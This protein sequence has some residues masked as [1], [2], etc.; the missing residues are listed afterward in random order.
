MVCKKQRFLLPDPGYAKDIRL[1]LVYLGEALDPLRCL[2]P[3]YL[4]YFLPDIICFLSFLNQ[5]LFSFIRFIRCI[6]FY[7]A[8][9]FIFRRFFNTFHIDQFIISLLLVFINDFLLQLKQ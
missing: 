3:L 8:F 9:L 6:Q 5:R 7:I 2:H 1:A 4:L